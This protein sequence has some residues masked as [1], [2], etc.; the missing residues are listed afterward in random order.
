[1]KME[2]D[3]KVERIKD[4]I[5]ESQID[6]YLFHEDIEKYNNKIHQIFVIGFLISYTILIFTVML[7]MSVINLI[8]VMLLVLLI[9]L[10]LRLCAEVVRERIIAPK[11]RDFFENGYCVS[12]YLIDGH[13]RIRVDELLYDKNDLDELINR[14]IEECK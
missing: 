11:Y 12:G 3:I 6:T 14:I 9:V 2:R 5:S 4:C 7:F 13:L 8:F 10:I 1:M